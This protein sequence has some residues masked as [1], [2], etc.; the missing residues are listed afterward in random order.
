MMQYFGRQNV[1]GPKAELAIN[2]HAETVQ[3][4]LGTSHR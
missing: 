1:R 2:C 3:V 4:E